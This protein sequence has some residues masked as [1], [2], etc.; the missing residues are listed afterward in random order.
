VTVRDVR[1]NLAQITSAADRLHL[2]L[3]LTQ[4][5]RR[6][7]E[8]LGEAGE[9]GSDPAKLAWYLHGGADGPPV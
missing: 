8:A 2:D 3:P 5:A 6:V 9:D 7:F 4:V 1:E